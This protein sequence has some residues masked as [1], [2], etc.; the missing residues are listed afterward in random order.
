M[1]FQSQQSGVRLGLV[2]LCKSSDSREN[3]GR[4]E[5]SGSSTTA[6]PVEIKQKLQACCWSGLCCL[7][8][9]LEHKKL[10]KVS[11][12][13]YTVSNA[14]RRTE[15]GPLCREKFLNS[16][17]SH[18]LRGRQDVQIETTCREFNMG[19]LDSEKYRDRDAGFEVCSLCVHSI[20]ENVIHSL[21]RSH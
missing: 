21:S 20:L 11:L 19:S 13:K 1:C 15:S 5:M 7:W 14:N 4:R 2:S 17:E 16:G 3:R 8:L 10:K 12:A 18:C 6:V 9:E